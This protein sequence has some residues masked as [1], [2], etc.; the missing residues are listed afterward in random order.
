MPG[1]KNIPT[2][3]K[4][5]KGNPGNRPLNES[6]PK[7]DGKAECPNW[8]QGDAK[9]EWERLAPQLEKLK[10]LTSL[11]RTAFAIYCEEWASYQ[12]CIRFIHKHGRTYT[13]KDADGNTKMV[14]PYPQVA[15]A[16][17]HICNIRSYASEFGF[18]PSSRGKIET[19]AIEESD[20]P[21]FDV[22]NSG[23]PGR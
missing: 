23:R 5:L 14:R 6:E 11:D 4:V 18:T 20:D 7:P 13:V 19:D 2:S 17:Q 12:E 3:L 21:M 15:Q 1:R 10:L 8:L 22:L 16:N 9:I